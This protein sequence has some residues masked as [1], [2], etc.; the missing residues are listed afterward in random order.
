MNHTYTI[1]NKC[2][3]VHFSYTRKEAQDEVDKFNEF[4]NTLSEEKQKSYYNGIG[5]S[6]K[7]YEHCFRCGASYTE[8]RIALKEELPLGS[9]I[10]PIIL[11]SEK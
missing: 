11:F 5:A 8:Q 3:W 6:I 7:S 9:T 4:F 1:C 10:Q 2:G